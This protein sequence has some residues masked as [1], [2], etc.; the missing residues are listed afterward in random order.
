M[1]SEAVKARFDK[2]VAKYPA[3]QKQSAVMACLA[4]VQQELGHI[5]ADS[6]QM[7]AD[8]LGMPPIA[9]HEV[10]TFY[11]MY[12]QRPVGKY[13]LNVCTNLPC[14]LRDGATALQ[15][16]ARRW[17]FQSQPLGGDAFDIRLGDHRFTAWVYQHG[18]RFAVFTGAG[19][20]LVTE[21]DP[22]AHAGDQAGE[23][24]RLTAP[25]P[26]KVIAF[27]AQPGEHVQRGQALAVMEAMKMEHTIAAPGAGTVAEIL[28]A[29]GDQ[30]GEGAGELGVEAAD[31]V[32]GL[33]AGERR[34]HRDL[35]T[36][37]GVAHQHAAQAEERAVLLAAGLQ[38]EPCAVTRVEAPAD[39]GAAH[40]PGEPWQPL[41]GK[42]EAGG[43]GGHVEQGAEVGQP[44]AV[45]PDAQQPLHRA[46]QRA[47]RARRQV[48]DV[49][50]D[51]ARVVAAVL[52]E[53][54]ADRR[55]EVVDRG[56]HHDDVAR[57]QGF[58]C[59]LAG[60]QGEE[61]VVEDLELAH[62]AV[63][64]VEDDRA[65]RGRHRRVRMLG[66]R[67]EV[68]DVALDLDEQRGRGAVGSQRGLEV[69]MAT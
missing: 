4:I 22:I 7:V 9:V 3:Q 64:E 36:P 47:A 45:V 52:A 62:R 63:G 50:G 12:N 32:V 6:E 37:G 42:A 20:A 68:A 16:G 17:T 65:V 26:G 67:G 25:M 1:I 40:P 57:A 48:G 59:V 56:H 33:D 19:S 11:N 46:H 14:Q 24:G 38:A 21:Y 10:T 69:G 54:R 41:L 27:L 30:V 51:V 49:E 18:E 43:D 29:P 60:E 5:S 23:A 53:D 13:K 58:A 66:E 2:E 35:R 8:Y 39:A 28:Y 44:A 34:V 31:L 55:R 15:L 61:L